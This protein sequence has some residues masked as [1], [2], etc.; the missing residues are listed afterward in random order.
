[1]LTSQAPRLA[2]VTFFR[3]WVFADDPVKMKSV[4]RSKMT[5]GLIKRRNF[6]TEI[7]MSP[8]EH[9]VNMKAQIGVINLLDKEHQR[10]PVTHQKLGEGHG[11]DPP[12]WPSEETSPAYNLIS[13]F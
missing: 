8:G 7:D 12:S 6:D 5:S 10:W 3:S 2:S 13:D 4:V 9:Y 1:M 11:T